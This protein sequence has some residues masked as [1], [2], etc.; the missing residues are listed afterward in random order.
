MDAEGVRRDFPFFEK[1]GSELVYLDSACQ[2]LRPRQVIEA[3]N[4]YY[5]DYPACG[6]RSVHRLATKVTLKLDESREAIA[7]LIGAAPDEVIF[8]K[9]ATESINIVANGFPL[10]RGDVVLTTDI[11]HNSNHLPWL[12]LSRNKGVGRV[13]LPTEAGMFDIET[14]KEFM[15][16]DVKV[17]SLV[18][19]SNVT[20]TTIQAREVIEIA[21]DQGA[22]VMLDGS[23]AAPHGPVDVRDL[24][25]DFYAMSLHKMLG[26]SGVGV[27]F[28][29]EELQGRVEPLILG[30]GSVSLSSYE[31]ME[32]LP[33]PEKFEAGL[34]NYA[35][36]IG[37]GP[38][39]RYLMRVGMD[40]VKEHI[41]SLNREASKGV[42]DIPEI[43]IVG[44]DDPDLRSGILSFNVEGMKSHDVATF[45][46]EMGGILL[47]SG[48]HC[49]HPFFRSR[50]MQG[51]VRASFYIY[52]T[53]E[54]CHRLVEVLGEMVELFAR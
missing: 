29:K 52:N 34:M 4:E 1:F 18:H 19:C 5:L 3:V 32:L 38:A 37:S 14:F 15:N 9:N 42:N 31:D 26:P 45:L 49:A 36:I 44:P 50:N 17:V 41:V 20:G 54:E 8:T 23:Q 25:V 22:F 6:G 7:S 12:R 16:G 35:G 2:T 53:R 33:P 27:L 28:A 11:E 48:M 40:N 10:G 39:V 24:D 51:A 43:G 47:R 13:F 46:D 21:H 30:G